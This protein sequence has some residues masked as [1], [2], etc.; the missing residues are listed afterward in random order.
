MSLV[1]TVLFAFIS[2]VYG[3]YDIFT[4]E[5]NSDCQVISPSLTVINCT[6]TSV[7]CSSVHFIFVT[8]TNVHIVCNDIEDINTPCLNLDFTL[9]NNVNV[10]VN[11]S[12]VTSVGTIA[13]FHNST[14]TFSDENYNEDDIYGKYFIKC[15][16]ILGT[17]FFFFFFKFVF[18]LV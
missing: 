1:F 9:Y 5:S 18:C 10:V 7:D 8:E 14:L 6:D 13:L 15:E 16:P 4:C 17:F 2:L 3:Q 12:K 11:G